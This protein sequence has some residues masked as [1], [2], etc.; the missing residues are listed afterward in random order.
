L[1][2]VWLVCITH[3]IW[4][5]GLSTLLVGV[6]PNPGPNRGKMVRQVGLVPSRKKKGPKAVDRALLES[7]KV[8]GSG[9]TSMTV[10]DLSNRP[11]NFNI[12]QSP[13]K[14]LGNQI[15]WFKET[16]S[17]SFTTS[18][19]TYAESNLS[20]QLSDL[21]DT[22]AIQGVFDQYCIYAVTVSYAISGTTSNPQLCIVELLTAID[23]DSTTNVGPTGIEA[24]STCMKSSLSANDSHVRLVKPCVNTGLYQAAGGGVFTSYGVNRC[25]IDTVSPNASH[26]GVRAVAF[27]NQAIVNI[28]VTR[29]YVIGCRN[30]Y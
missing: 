29:E 24:Y 22:S 28:A 17:S 4:L 27:Q 3:T 21:P 15:W 19:S 1:R 12:V 2:V 16:V 9:T 14:Q 26:Y 11:Q 30:K 13:P 5:I 6:E 10:F 25:W 8:T 20:F 7:A 18:T 23:Y